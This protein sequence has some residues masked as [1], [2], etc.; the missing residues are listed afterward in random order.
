[1]TFFP[2]ALVFLA[3]LIFFSSSKIIRC[4]RKFSNSNLFEL[5]LGI[6]HADAR[7]SN[8]SC[9][10]ELGDRTRIHG[11]ENVLNRMDFDNMPS[12]SNL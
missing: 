4:D 1:M 8:V 9:I 12:I 6:L 3:C 10:V 2:I 5:S 7:H 11:G